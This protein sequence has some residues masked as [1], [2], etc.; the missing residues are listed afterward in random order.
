MKSILLTRALVPFFVLGLSLFTQCKK[1]DS[2]TDAGSVKVEITDAPIDDANVSGTFITVADVKIDGS[3]MSG[4]SGKQTI[5]LLAYQN[6]NVKSLGTGSLDAGSHSTVSLVLDYDKDASGN[7]PG[8]YVLTKDGVKHALKSTVN[9]SS[10]I[11]STADFTSTATSSTNLVLDFDVRKAVTYSGSA[12]SDYEFAADNELRTSVRVVTKTNAGTIKGTCTDAL[13]TSEKIVVYAYKKG[14]F[15]A[16]TEK[17][18]TVQFKNAVT[19]AAVDAQGNYT[20]AF[21]NAGNY[22]LHFIGYEDANNDGK[23]EL[24]GSLLLTIVGALDLNNVTVGAQANVN[25][26]VVVTGILPL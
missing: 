23:F 2:G 8:C 13:G 5:D 3:S 21:L 25:L 4:F 11:T 16:A 22:E 24:E 7:S 26:N 6:G 1:D 18:G 9:T 12:S 15:N 14:T 10:E 20:L 17:A 19:S